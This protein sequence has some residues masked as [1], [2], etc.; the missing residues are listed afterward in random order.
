ML[1]VLLLFR[2]EL[3]PRDRLRLVLAELQVTPLGCW[4]VLSPTRLTITEASS[5]Q[6]LQSGLRI[7][8]GLILIENPTIFFF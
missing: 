2:V 3:R 1:R 6:P 5:V 4:A 8:S 7:Q